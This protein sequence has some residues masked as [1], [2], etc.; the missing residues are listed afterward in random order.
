MFEEGI[1]KSSETGHILESALLLQD[2]ENETEILNPELSQHYSTNL[3]QSPEPS[4]CLEEKTVF[5]GDH[6]KPA[7]LV[8]T[9]TQRNNQMNTKREE[10]FNGSEDRSARQTIPNF[11]KK[12]EPNL[13]D[14]IDLNDLDR[15]TSVEGDCNLCKRRYHSR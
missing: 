1:N 2:L 3:N 15:Y 7:T 9:E 14:Y 13:P 6:V 4:L 8:I 10:T 11:T 12:E 5:N